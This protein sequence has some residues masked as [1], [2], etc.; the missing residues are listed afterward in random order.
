MNNDITLFIVDKNKSVYRVE[1]MDTV[2]K[3]APAR[4]APWSIVIKF[5]SR[6]DLI[7]YS[8]PQGKN[9]HHNT[10]KLRLATLPL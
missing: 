2:K 5:R 3:V 8:S 4:S 9:G 6:I 7:Q 10:A 1:I